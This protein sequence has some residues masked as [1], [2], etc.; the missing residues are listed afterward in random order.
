M[1]KEGSPRDKTTDEPEPS[2]RNFRNIL[3]FSLFPIDLVEQPL[4]AMDAG[5]DEVQGNHR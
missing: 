4:S 3:C 1:S 2:R 5:S